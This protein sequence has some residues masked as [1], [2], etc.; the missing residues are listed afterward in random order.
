MSNY[1][2]PDFKIIYEVN[3]SISK[4]KAFDYQQW[5]QTFTQ[6]V[7]E[8]IDGFTHAIVYSQP[9]PVGLHWLSEEKEKDYFTVH[10]HVDSQQHLED[11]L[12]RHQN[13]I[14]HAQESIWGYLVIS[15]RILKLQSATRIKG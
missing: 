3:L 5:L 10:Y 6:E 9:K 8:T 7:C 13:S 11:Y 1:N 2:L 4:E 14:A 15:R 12:D